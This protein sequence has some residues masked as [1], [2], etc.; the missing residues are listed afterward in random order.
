[1]M[2]LDKILFIKKKNFIIAYISLTVYYVKPD[3]L[4]KS[5]DKISHFLYNKVQGLNFF[6]ILVDKVT[7]KKVQLKKEKN[8]LFTLGSMPSVFCCP[9]DF[10][11]TLEYF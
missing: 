11:L 5:Y 10:Y 6:V 3:I 9:N 7:K 8:N 1:M 2:F 4:N